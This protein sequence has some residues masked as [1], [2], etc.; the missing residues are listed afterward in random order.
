[1]AAMSVPQPPTL[2][3]ALRPRARC[4]SGSSSRRLRRQRS[5]ASLYR[6]QQLAAT[7]GSDACQLAVVGDWRV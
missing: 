6:Q 3:T 7:T 5:R 1:M 2:A 4:S